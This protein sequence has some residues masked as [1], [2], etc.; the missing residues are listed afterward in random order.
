MCVCLCVCIGQFN[1]IQLY[2][3]SEHY[4]HKFHEMTD[5]KQSLGWLKRLV[6]WWIKVQ[7]RKT[8]NILTKSI[9]YCSRHQTS[10]PARPRRPRTLTTVR[11]ERRA[12]RMSWSVPGRVWLQYASSQTEDEPYA[13]DVRCSDVSACLC[14][15]ICSGADR[16]VL[17]IAF[18]IQRWVIKT[19]NERKVIFRSHVKHSAF[20]L[21]AKYSSALPRFFC[22]FALLSDPHSETL[23]GADALKRILP[24]EIKQDW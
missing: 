12:A 24:T 3:N 21:K 19:K 22:V 17:V 6:S 18:L 2:L 23:G 13:A 4:D 1:D 11:W 20:T 14:V 10:V 7:L 5:I 8:T 9:C 15:R 16:Y